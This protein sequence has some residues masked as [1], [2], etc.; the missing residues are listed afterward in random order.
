MHHEGKLGALEENA[1][2]LRLLLGRDGFLTRVFRRV[3]ECFA[4]DFHPARHD[5]TAVERSWR[6]RLFGE[7]G[8]LKNVLRPSPRAA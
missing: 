4:R 5:T 8:S 1:R 2:G 7:A 6:E 3:P